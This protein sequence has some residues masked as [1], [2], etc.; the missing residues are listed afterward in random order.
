MSVRRLVIA[1]AIALVAFLIARAPLSLAGA[2][3]DD[4]FAYGQAEGTVWRGTFRNAN[5]GGHPLGDVKVSLSP[6]SLLLLKARVSFAFRGV[7]AEGRG[8]LERGAFGGVALR[9]AKL[10]GDLERLSISI[11]NAPRQAGLVTADVKAIAFGPSGCRRAEADLWTDVLAQDDPRWDWTGPTLSGAAACAD[12]V[13]VL[14]LS[15]VENGQR[16]MLTTEVRP[17]LAYVFR[18][19]VET[20]DPNLGGVLTLLGFQRKDSGFEYTQDGVLRLSEL[21]S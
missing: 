18:A 15:G 19:S 17:N 9:D 13:L 5:L 12:G 16:I 3:L 11:A 1:F 6:A 10:K 20:E 7:G 2:F 4:S 21:I 8:V 14:P